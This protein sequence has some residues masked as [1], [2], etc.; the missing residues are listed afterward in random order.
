MS[1]ATKLIFF[2]QFTLCVTANL[3]FD[4]CVA[5]L[6]PEIILIQCS[7][8]ATNFFS[9][10][11]FVRYLV[12]TNSVWIFQIYA[13]DSVN[14][15]ARVK[16]MKEVVSGTLSQTMCWAVWTNANRQAGRWMAY[17]VRLNTQI[18]WQ[19]TSNFRCDQRSFIRFNQHTHTKLSHSLC[20]WAA[21]CGAMVHR[22]TTNIDV[23]LSKQ[24]RCR[25]A[26][27]V[28]LFN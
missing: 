18:K 16:W 6:K 1:C 21:T 20:L 7:A 24:I 14:V 9:P 15:R 8:R 19:K 28:V 22:I 23:D 11:Y 27:C 17:L 5:R 26:L 10:I 3:S 2:I 25:A 12:E 4:L 13:C